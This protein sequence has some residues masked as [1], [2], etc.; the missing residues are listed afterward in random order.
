MKKYRYALPPLRMLSVF[1]AA[2]RFENFTTAANTLCVTQAAVSKTVQALEADLGCSLFVRSGRNIRLTLQGQELYEKTRSALNYLEESCTRI[3]VGRNEVSTT[4][5]ANT[6]VSHY[7]LASR[8]REYSLY[9]PSSS[10]RLVISDK[11]QDFFDVENGLAV[12]YGHKNRIG[13]EQTK[14]FDEEVFPVA[15]K[16]FLEKHGLSDRLPLEPSEIAQLP[17]LDYDLCE[18]NWIDFRRWLEWTGVTPG[19]YQPHRVF[20]SYVLAVDA[21]L[22]GEGFVLG[23]S[24]LLPEDLMNNDVVALSDRRFLTGRGYFL[25]FQSGAKLDDETQKL[26]QWLVDNK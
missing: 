11:D 6:A 18:I 21:M 20:S 22:A 19:I 24:S 8:L 7:W 25:G 4:I 9:A 12:L 14:L 5:I 13:W 26:F 3:R 23:S 10:V 17:M 1:E 2:A 15:T 16:A